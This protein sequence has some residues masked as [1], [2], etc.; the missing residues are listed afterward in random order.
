MKKGSGDT[1]IDLGLKSVETLHLRSKGRGEGR[2][3]EVSQ[4]EGMNTT[5]TRRP[6]DRVQHYEFLSILRL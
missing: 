2:S 6:M 5:C 1:K 4:S 3:N